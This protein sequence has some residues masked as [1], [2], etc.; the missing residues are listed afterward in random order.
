MSLVSPSLRDA[1]GR[2]RWRARVVPVILT[3]RLA[4]Q[5]AG[6]AVR[7]ATRAHLGSGPHVLEGWANL[8]L[9]GTNGVVR[10][11][12]TKPLPFPPASLDHIFSEHFI[13]HIR[14]DQAR[15]LLAEC[16]RTLRAN[17]VLRISTPDL[18]RLVHEYLSGH[19]DEWSDMGWTP[20]SGC[21]LI[22]EGMRAWGHQYVWDEEQL[23]DMLRRAGF[24]SITRVVRHLS[25]HPEL[26]GLESR[27]DHG[28]L[29]LEARR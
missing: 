12:L 4:P 21:D 3:S 18:R 24:T 8:D 17:G 10:F 1:L 14:L 13:E 25:E 22:N 5:L 7:G 20:A 6:R 9:D 15:A 23:M 27:P 26:R 19:T 11:D 2:V 28:D 16:H 29:I